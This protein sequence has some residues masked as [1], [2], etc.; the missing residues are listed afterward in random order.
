[1]RFRNFYM[2]RD[3][4][5]ATEPAATTTTAPLVEPRPDTMVAAINATN[6]KAPEGAEKTT[7][8]AASTEKKPIFEGITG[9][10]YTQEE[11]TAYTK[12]LETNAVQN[13]L[14]ADLNAGNQQ[15]TLAEQMAGEVKTTEEEKTKEGLDPD[16]MFSD[17][18][19]F[20][21]DMYTK[22][23][24][25]IEKKNAKKAEGEKYWENFYVKHESLR[26]HKEMVDMVTN[27]NW[28]HIEKMQTND[29]EKFIVDKTANLI[30]SIR[31]GA[32]QKEVEILENAQS[33]TVES[34]Q[35]PTGAPVEVAETDTNFT[36]DFSKWQDKKF[37][38]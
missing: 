9:P 8:E 24:T 25:D 16:E 6:K 11:L 7:T 17:P 27:Q 23:M 22:V 38:R 1:M 20:A 3:E 33:T 4:V 35:V 34:T 26:E 28:A 30:N 31:K 19:K 14:A 21:K 12:S 15:T 2:L 32:G 5:P 10:L 13:R 36:Q 18:D 29:A 37:G